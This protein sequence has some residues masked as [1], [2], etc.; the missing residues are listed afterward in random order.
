MRTIT[1]KPYSFG[2]YVPVDVWYPPPPTMTHFSP[3]HDARLLT[4]PGAA[5]ETS[6][7]ISFEYDR[8]MDGCVTSGSEETSSFAP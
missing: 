2:A 7:D 5:N 3:G 8:E 1:L 4:I 6:F